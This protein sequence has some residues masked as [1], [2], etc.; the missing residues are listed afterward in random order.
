[1]SPTHA[2]GVRQG[3]TLEAINRLV[4]E[5]AVK[6]GP[7]AGRVSIRVGRMGARSDELLIYSIH[8]VKKAACSAPGCSLLQGCFKKG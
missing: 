2:K 6:L 7:A 4:V 5:A 1:M 8:T 3:P